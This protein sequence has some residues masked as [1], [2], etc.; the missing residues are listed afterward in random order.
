M[1]DA[2]R[3]SDDEGIGI[4]F[5]CC[6]ESRP[7][8]GYPVG[9][10]SWNIPNAHC[11][12]VFDEHNWL[13][14]TKKAAYV[15]L[16]DD[17]F[18]N[19][20]FCPSEYPLMMSADFGFISASK[21]KTRG[22]TYICCKDH[23]HKDSSSSLLDTA[24]L[25][26]DN[27][28]SMASASAWQLNTKGMSG[29]HCTVRYDKN[30]IFNWKLLSDDTYQN[31]FGCPSAFPTLMR[32]ELHTNGT[33]TDDAILYWCCKNPVEPGAGPARNS[34]NVATDKVDGD[35]HCT[36]LFDANNW[37]SNS[38][39]LSAFQDETFQND[40]A[41]PS[42]FPRMM[43]AVYRKI[44]GESGAVGIQFF[45][46]KGDDK[47]EKD[48]DKVDDKDDDKADGEEKVLMTS[49]WNMPP[50]KK[51]SMLFDGNNW[52]SNT[53]K[54][55]FNDKS[56][57]NNFGC[58][59]D[60]KTLMHAEMYD[61]DEDGSQVTGVMFF[62]CDGGKAPPVEAG[63]VHGW[64]MEDDDDKVC[65]MAYDQ[66]YWLTNTKKL[67]FILDTTFQNNFDCPSDFPVLMNAKLRADEDNLGI[68]FFCCKSSQSSSD[69]VRRRTRRRRD[70]DFNRLD[71]EFR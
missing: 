34:W 33:G 53:H 12:M 38:K 46:C 18:Q 62:C 5:T 22:I 70:I 15:G 59:S 37:V 69:D 43:D 57:T 61:G 9:K 26:K 52:F 71:K 2:T 66:N 3:W 40:F 19:D 27:P 8:N 24:P 49:G 41:C 14:N 16:D 64:Y 30:S 23:G 11:T 68:V 10:L 6:K 21:A 50:G 4:V 47:P 7:L 51:C 13:T 32:A 63:S 58:P 35:K 1:M 25:A 56:Y 29:K 20:F 60:I 55:P 48:D 54:S 45:C 36:M 65:A 17:T 28:S 44:P 42:G 39:K 67:A 31:N